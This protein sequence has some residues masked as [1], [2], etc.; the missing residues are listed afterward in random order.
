MCTVFGQPLGEKYIVNASEGYPLARQALTRASFVSWGGQAMGG[1]RRIDKTKARNSSTLISDYPC[2]VLSKQD[3]VHA[4]LSLVAVSTGT[5]HHLRLDGHLKLRGSERLGSLNM[6]A[7]QEQTNSTNRESR[8]EMEIEGTRS[9]HFASEAAG[10]PSVISPTSSIARASRITT[11]LSTT[12]IAH[13]PVLW[14]IQTHF[15]QMRSLLTFTDSSCIGPF[16][17]PQLPPPPP[18]TELS[19]SDILTPP[20]PRPCGGSTCSRQRPNLYAFS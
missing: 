19:L 1:P 9:S 6:R 14:R 10:P 2:G 17:F 16:V 3:S 5:N 12:N 15:H 4:Q 13:C 8:D 20:P 7:Q 11:T 18:T